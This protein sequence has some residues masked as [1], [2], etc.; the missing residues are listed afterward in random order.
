MLSAYIAA[1]MRRAHYEM[2]EDQPDAPFYGSIPGLQGVLAVGATLEACREELQ[3]AL[4]AW[5]L[6]GLRFGD[7]LPIIDDIDLNNSTQSLREAA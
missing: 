4:E 6:I 3:G 5:L 1:A 7:E 2:L